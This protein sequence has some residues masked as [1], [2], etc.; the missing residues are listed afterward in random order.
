MP[1]ST[2]SANRTEGEREVTLQTKKRR[3]KAT[4]M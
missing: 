2:V 4:K 1:L 3:E